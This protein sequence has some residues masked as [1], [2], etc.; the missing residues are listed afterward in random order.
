MQHASVLVPF[1]L[2]YP[3]CSTTLFTRDTVFYKGT[4]PVHERKQADFLGWGGFKIEGTTVQCGRKFVGSATVTAHLPFK[5]DVGCGFSNLTHFV[6]KI[7]AVLRTQTSGPFEVLPPEQKKK[8]KKKKRT[9]VVSE[10]VRPN[11]PN[12]PAYG[13]AMGG[14]SG[15]HSAELKTLG[16]E[17]NTFDGEINA[18]VSDF[19]KLP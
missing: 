17:N 2:A 11:P 16:D 14:M 10:G 8:K 4:D 5:T 12:P 3:W 15:K 1:A 18:K 7:A 13:P 6:G 9:F 19:T